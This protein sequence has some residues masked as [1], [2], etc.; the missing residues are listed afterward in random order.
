MDART[1]ASTSTRTSRPT[2]SG[3][4]ATTP[5][6]PRPR[7]TSA[8]INLTRFSLYFPEKRTFFLEGSEIFNFGTTSAG[9]GSGFAPFFSRRIGLFEGRAGPDL[10]RGQGLREDRRHQPPGPRRPD[11]RRLEDLDLPAENFLAA[12]VSQNI[13]AESKVGVIFTDGS[14]TGSEELPGRLRLRLPDLAVPQ[15]QE[16]PRRRLVRLQLER[17]DRRAATRASASGSTTPTTSGTS[18]TSYNSYGD[19]LDP[20][21]GFL[22]RPG[23]Q[24][25]NLGVSY[26]PAAREGVRRRASSASSSTSSASP[27]PGTSRGGS[28]RG[29]SS[30]PRST[31]RPRA[32][33]TSSSTSSRTTTSCPRTWRSPTG[34]S[35]RA[36]AYT[37]TNYAVQFETACHRPWGGRVE[38]GVR[39]VLFRATTTTSKPGSRLKFKGYRDASTSTPTSSAAGSP[40]GTSRRT[41]TSSRPISSSRPAWG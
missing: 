6:S 19:A 16:L 31:C 2:S 37:F 38:V 39:P 27:S 15:G 41:S 11:A 28:R 33:S 40:R 5:I 30:P 1:A 14:P 10:F 21:V 4:S 29:A 17:P 12:R 9:N 35:C 18:P 7:S 23:V 8:Q 25:F 26:M 22:P 20:G 34:S 3:P 36:G 32:A 13:W 24:V